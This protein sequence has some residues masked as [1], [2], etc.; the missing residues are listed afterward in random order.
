MMNEIEIQNNLKKII[1]QTRIIIS[2]LEANDIEIVLENLEERNRLIESIDISEVDKRHLEL[3]P[4]LEE[5]KTLNEKCIFKL[6]ANKRILETEF[7]AFQGEKKLT[8]R[9]QK[10]QEKYINPYD[11]MLSSTFDLKK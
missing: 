6:K 5:F 2:A 10:T 1:E 8:L 7:D 4:F 9:N 11:Y 3:T